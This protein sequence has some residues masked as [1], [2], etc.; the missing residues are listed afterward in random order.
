M[1]K[2]RSGC[3]ALWMNGGV[4]LDIEMKRSKDKI[5]EYLGD[6]NIRVKFLPVAVRKHGTL[7]SMPFQHML[8][9]DIQGMILVA[10][11]QKP[12]ANQV[13]RWHKAGMY[14]ADSF[15]AYNPSKDI[16]VRGGNFEQ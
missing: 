13:V 7:M 9:E 5:K 11:K 8:L 6:Q 10:S 3:A 4:K 16:I 15:H 1:Q 2:M 12:P 14:N